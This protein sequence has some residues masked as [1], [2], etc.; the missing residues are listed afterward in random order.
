VEG[1][2]ETDVAGA[3]GTGDGWGCVDG[4]NGNAMA[5]NTTMLA[6]ARTGIMILAL[7]KTDKFAFPPGARVARR[8]EDSPRQGYY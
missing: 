3:S 1:F 2:A 4:P 5:R 8:M 7:T 6:T